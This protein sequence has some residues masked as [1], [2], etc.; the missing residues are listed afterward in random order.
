MLT[1]ITKVTADW[2]DVKNECRNTINKEYS[3]KETTTDFKKKILISEHS[4]IR[5]I[6]IKWRWKGIKSWISVHFSSFWMSLIA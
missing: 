3:N 5:L 2:I 4:P 6:K 1:N